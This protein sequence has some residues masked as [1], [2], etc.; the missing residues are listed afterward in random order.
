M[1]SS[2]SAPSNPRHEWYQTDAKVVVT[3]LVKNVSPESVHVN[4]AKEN[5]SISIK[6]PSN[7]DCN[8]NFN[9]S[10]PIVP[11][12]C[13][14]RVTP[15][16]IELHLAKDSALKWDSLEKKVKVAK[17]KASPKNWDAVAKDLVSDKDEESINTLFNQLYADGSDETKRAMLKSYY[18]SGGTVLSTD[19]NE[20]SKQKV[21]V[22]PPEGVEFKGWND[23]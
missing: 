21:E 3:L 23:K 22:K 12:K 17:P 13:S 1:E 14:F 2:S 9:L 19:W 10:Q 7:E 8:L 5:V 20:V 6:L 4:F 11:E 15:L 16:K 18:E